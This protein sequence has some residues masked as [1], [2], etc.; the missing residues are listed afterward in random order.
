MFYLGPPPGCHLA[1][2]GCYEERLFIDLKMRIPALITFIP[3]VIIFIVLLIVFASF[4]YPD[5]LNK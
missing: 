4:K 2:V 5:R 1:S 3:I